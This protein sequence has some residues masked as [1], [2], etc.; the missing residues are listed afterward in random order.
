MENNNKEE[1]A[2]DAF[3]QILKEFLESVNRLG[4]TAKRL[5]REVPSTIASDITSSGHSI[6]EKF[7]KSFSEKEEIDWFT[8]ADSVKDISSLVEKLHS[9]MGME[10]NLSFDEI[11]DLEKIVDQIAIL[12]DI[13]RIKSSDSM[14]ELFESKNDNIKSREKLINS[15]LKEFEEKIE[16]QSRFVES[17]G[18]NA[19]SQMQDMQGSARAA[20]ENLK[21]TY[22]KESENFSDKNK[23]TDELLR[24]LSTGVL[25]GGHSGRAIEE[26]KQANIFRF[27][28][29]I[30]MSGV[31][32]FAYE[33]YKSANEIISYM[34]LATRIGMIFAVLLLIT[35][36]AKESGKHR[37]LGNRYYQ[38]ALDLKALDPYISDLSAETK[39]RIKA[40]LA[41]R[42]FF[43]YDNREVQESAPLNA[44]E[45][46]M[47]LMDLASKNKS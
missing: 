18:Q 30:L 16:K 3:L 11:N 17:I 22:E 43:V 19:N 29:I 38:T 34:S 40:D 12:V 15:K 26:I 2:D 47:K 41:I 5:K 4:K 45:I 44:Q 35:Y 27:L 28:T 7:D 20:L 32:F 39:E 36:F 6:L 42:M 46:I 13:S 14:G 31:I 10:K 9:A 33:I 25:L 8:T 1:N 24:K 37:V 21:R 23:E